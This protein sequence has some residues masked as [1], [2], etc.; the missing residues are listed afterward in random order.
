MARSGGFTPWGL[1]PATERCVL[2]TTETRPS[3]GFVPGLIEYRQRPI[4]FETRQI[5]RRLSAVKTEVPDET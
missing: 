4:N 1:S 2:Q 3:L 5:T